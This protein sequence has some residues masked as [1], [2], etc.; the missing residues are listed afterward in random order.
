VLL[1]D[2]NDIEV[3][4]ASSTLLQIFVDEEEGHGFLPSMDA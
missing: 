2:L 3:R 1:F 4:E